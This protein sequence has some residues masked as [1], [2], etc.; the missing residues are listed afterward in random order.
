MQ[1]YKA[2]CD[3]TSGEV[4]AEVLSTDFEGM[5]TEGEE[6]AK[7]AKNIVVKIPMTADGLESD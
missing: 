3:I 7:I 1:H 6:L 2:I 5:I 4:S